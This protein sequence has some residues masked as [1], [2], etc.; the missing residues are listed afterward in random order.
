[1]VLKLSTHVHEGQPRRFVQVLI[2]GCE[3]TG[4]LKRRWQRSC[5][6]IRAVRDGRAIQSGVWPS[7]TR[8]KKVRAQSE[9]RRKKKTPCLSVA[10]TCR[11]RPFQDTR[12]YYKNEDNSSKL[13]NLT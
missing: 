4:F 3:C 2:N 10:L 12:P 5:F 13:T 8:G 1:M 9:L 11:D 6:F 7:L